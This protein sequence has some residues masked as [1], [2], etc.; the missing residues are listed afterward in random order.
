MTSDTISFAYFDNII[1]GKRHNST[2]RSRAI[3]PSTCSPL[4]EVAV[5]TDDDT[6]KAIDAAQKSF[7]EWSQTSWEQR[8]DLVS[9]LRATLLK[10][11]E[12]M[13]ELLMKEAG[14]PRAFANLEVEHAARFLEFHANSK[15]PEEVIIQDDKELQLTERLLPIGVVAA[16]S[17]WN[18][19]LVLAVGKIGAALITGNCVIV[20]PSPFT[21]Y[22]VLKLAEMAIGIF[23]PGVFQAL[24]GDE[25][26]GPFLVAHPGIS[27]ISF[28]GSTATGKKIMAAASNTLK[29]ITLELGGNNATIICPDINIAK[30]APQV[31][32]G[33]FF[34]SGQL[35]VASKRIYVH[36]NIYSEFMNAITKVVK[37]WKVGPVSDQE[38]M[39]GPV[40]NHTQF[41]IVQGFY[42]DCR[43]N[44]YK[45]A[46]G[47]DGGVGQGYLLHPAIIDNP[48]DSSRIVQEEPFGPII[49]IQ[50][51]SS[52]D[53]LLSRV[54][55]TLSGLGGSVWTSDATRAQR[56]ARRIEAGTIWINS[57]EKP[58]PQGYFSGH[59]ESGLGGEWGIRGLYSYC[60]VQTIHFYKDRV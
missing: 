16:I 46:I 26:L 32:L 42:E 30:V 8:Q 55:N 35:C 27:K 33:A 60:K 41:T 20:K 34:N 22:S 10:Y 23:P 19:P 15:L 6:E 40:Q 4:W 44:G 36:E 1:N 45:F 3:D 29:S 28:T 49:P 53:E 2:S 58:L 50:S 52:E 54:N 9:K 17:P 47:E 48:P 51:W 57:F 12:E 25:S 11:R 43:R 13:V 39:L 21:P 37:S 59:K 31:A 24:N 7:S 56:I 18:F 38:V 14:K 5:A